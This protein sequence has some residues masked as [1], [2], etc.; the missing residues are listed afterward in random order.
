MVECERYT[1]DVSDVENKVEKVQEK[2]Y[3]I[4][5]SSCQH[6]T[7]LDLVLHFEQVSLREHNPSVDIKLRFPYRMHEAIN[8]YDPEPIYG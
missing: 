8:L 1:D 5:K 4:S 2:R 3:G 6:E 7:L